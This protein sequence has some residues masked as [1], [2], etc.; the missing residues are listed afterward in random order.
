MAS[1]QDIRNQGLANVSPA[2][3]PD[4]LPPPVQAST[5]L[6]SR[7]VQ[8]VAEEKTE[9]TTEK[10]NW[11]EV[12]GL[13]L[14]ILASIL[15]LVS[16]PVLLLTGGELSWMRT[17]K[18]SGTHAIILVLFALLSVITAR[19]ITNKGSRFCAKKI[20]TR[21]WALKVTIVVWWICTLIIKL[22]YKGA[23]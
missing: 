1:A 7:P 5:P 11:F 10:W 22:F 20:F 9:E 19:E 2:P 23:W 12:I 6:P 13:G 17:I 4:Q 3:V 21:W 18:S 15:L 14:F 16:L 8:P